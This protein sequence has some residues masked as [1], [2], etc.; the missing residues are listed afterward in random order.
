MRA[1][2]KWGGGLNEVLAMG[3]GK[4]SFTSAS[5]IVVLKLP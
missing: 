5:Y 3:E 1:P 4:P 2:G